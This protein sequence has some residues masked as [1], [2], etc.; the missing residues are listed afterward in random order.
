MLNSICPFLLIFLL[1][2]TAAKQTKEHH[3]WCGFP[4]TSGEKSICHPF[5]CD[6]MFDR[7][8]EKG[9]NDQSKS[10]RQNVPKVSGCN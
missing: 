10:D 7:N 5:Y 6:E 2:V 1:D 8:R 9:H 3:V 4:G